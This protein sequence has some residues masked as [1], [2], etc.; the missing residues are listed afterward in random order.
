MIINDTYDIS[1]IFN[2]V[3]GVDQQIFVKSSLMRRIKHMLTSE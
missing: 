1:L 3:D 2:K